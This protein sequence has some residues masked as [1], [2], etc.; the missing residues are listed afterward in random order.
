MLKLA[1][2]AS[3]PTRSTGTPGP[4]HA[5]GGKTSMGAGDVVSTQAWVDS[6]GSITRRILR[7]MIASSISSGRRSPADADLTTNQDDPRH[8]V[9]IAGVRTSTRRPACRPGM[10]AA[11][12]ASLVG[13]GSVA[14][15][16]AV[17]REGEG[18]SGKGD[19][20]VFVF[21]ATRTRS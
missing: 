7:W 8:R 20:A 16:E 9:A 12:P 19:H 14:Q 10:L 21:C 17:G 15:I 4:A 13:H 1:L 18:D 3:V 5:P 6:P 11:I 2:A